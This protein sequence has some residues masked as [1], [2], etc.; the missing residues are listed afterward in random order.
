MARGWAARRGVEDAPP[1]REHV[2]IMPH[3]IFD[4]RLYDGYRQT[5]DAVPASGDQRPLQIDPRSPMAAVD[6]A[7][8]FISEGACML[9]LEPALFGAD[10]LL[11]LK[12][13]CPVPL[14]PFSVSGEYLRLTDSGS[15][16]R[17][18][19]ELFTFLKRSGSDRIITYAASEL[20]R[21]LS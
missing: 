13:T 7:L 20:A 6:A 19:L 17:L 4:S 8:G 5:M 12:R 3:L 2:S 14:S 9:L 16:W 21:A 15:D 18:L 10:V 1:P 11:M